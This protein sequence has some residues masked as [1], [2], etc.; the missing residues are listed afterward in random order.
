MSHPSVLL[1][2]ILPDDELPA[3][4]AAFGLDPGGSPTNLAG[5][6][7]FSATKIE[8]RLAIQRKIPTAKLKLVSFIAQGENSL[9]Q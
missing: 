4:L 6:S 8:W 5:R 7:S 3:V 1:V 9:C 2:T